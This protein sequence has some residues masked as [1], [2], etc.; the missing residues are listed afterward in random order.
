MGVHLSPIDGS[1]SAMGVPWEW[2]RTRI[3]HKHFIQEN[4][5]R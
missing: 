5:I 1:G 4:I 3:L 2:V